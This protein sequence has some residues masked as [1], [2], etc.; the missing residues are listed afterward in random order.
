MTAKRLVLDTSVA[1]YLLQTTAPVDQEERWRQAQRL[2]S[3]PEREWTLCLPTP[4]LAE[5]LAGVSADRRDAALDL[6]SKMFEIVVF[7]RDAA[8]VAADLVNPA[9][10]GP[11]TASKQQIKVDVEILACAIRWKADG[12]CAYDGDHEAILARAHGRLKA[13]PPERFLPA[14][15]EMFDDLGG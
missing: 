1:L 12:I 11:R 8:V 5:V 4:A 15:E 7:D 13:G 2:V 14:Q 10:R 6:L 9:L 3:L